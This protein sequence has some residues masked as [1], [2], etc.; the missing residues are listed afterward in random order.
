MQMSGTETSIGGI[1]DFAADSELELLHTVSARATPS[2]VVSEEAYSFYRSLI[3]DELRDH[4]DE[5]DGV[6][7]ALHEVMVTEVAPDGEGPL[8]SAVR[9]IVGPDIPVVATLDLHANVTERMV[10]AADA[11]TAYE[12]YPLDKAETGVKAFDILVE[13]MRGTIKPT[14]HFERPPTIIFQPKA[15]TTHGPITNSRGTHA[16][17]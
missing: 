12:E 3:L 1:I 6:V 16:R 13:A 5:I 11:L 14:I 9:S 7:L 4:I 17:A 8:F 10:E 2:G 15:H